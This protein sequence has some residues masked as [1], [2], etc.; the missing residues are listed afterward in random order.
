MDQE[1]RGM[2]L[3]TA[4]RLF[5]DKAT[6]DVVNALEKGNWPADLWQAVEEMGLPTVGVS[7]A[8]GGA[9]GSLTDLL[10]LIKL[11]AYHAL[12]VPLAETGLASALLDREA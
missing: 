12:P 2:L 1:T 4:G 5:A 9:G 7:E 10:A 8:A 6:K 3:E 11:A